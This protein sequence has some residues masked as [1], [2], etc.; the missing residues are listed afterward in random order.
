MTMLN[1]MREMLRK[2]EA[3]EKLANEKAWQAEERWDSAYKHLCILE[4][5]CAEY[6]DAGKPVPYDLDTAYYTA[7]LHND[8]CADLA[9]EAE[10]DA[11]QWNEVR[12]NLEKAVEALERM[13]EFKEWA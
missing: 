3:A 12:H 4:N 5:K 13:W 6:E 1:E 11:I 9:H 8:A 2:A 7:T 10:E